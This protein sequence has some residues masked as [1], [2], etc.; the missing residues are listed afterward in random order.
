MEKKDRML[1]EYFESHLEIDPR[2][3][4][5]RSVTIFYFDTPYW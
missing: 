3:K 1:K 5:T 4:G 2:I